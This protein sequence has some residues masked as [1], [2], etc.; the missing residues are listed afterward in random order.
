LAIGSLLAT[1]GVVFF[2]MRAGGNGGMSDNM[3]QV[4][5][6]GSIIS[7]VSVIFLPEQTGTR[8]GTMVAMLI[9]AVLIVFGIYLMT[10][11]L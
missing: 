8:T 3:F 11:I 4:Q 7:A 6:W 9:S 10:I 2:R 1:A 5:L